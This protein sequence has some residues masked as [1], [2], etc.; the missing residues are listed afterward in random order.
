MSCDSYKL[1]NSFSIPE[2]VVYYFAIKKVSGRLY[3]RKKAYLISKCTC[4][5]QFAAFIAL[6]KANISIVPQ[7]SKC[8]KFEVI[9]GDQTDQRICIQT[10]RYNKTIA[11]SIV[12]RMAH[13]NHLIHLNYPYLSFVNSS[14][15]KVSRALPKYFHLFAYYKTSLPKSLKFWTF[16]PLWRYNTWHLCLTLVR[17]LGRNAEA[18]GAI[19]AFLCHLPFSSISNC[20][21]LK[22]ALFQSDLCCQHQN[23]NGGR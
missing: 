6:F 18:F 9:R 20:F 13:H 1:S 3:D 23:K 22:P 12:Q 16:T 17:M 14:W 11:C 2:Y 19:P 7:L 5:S 15:Q 8:P 4:S 10:K 21:A